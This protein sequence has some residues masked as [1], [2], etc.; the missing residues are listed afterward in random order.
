MPTLGGHEFLRISVIGQQQP[1]V[2]YFANGCSVAASRTGQFLNNP[3]IT[4]RKSS[5][6]HLFPQI[7]S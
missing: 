5:Y 6:I 2:L 1:P 4:A 7:Q 3:A